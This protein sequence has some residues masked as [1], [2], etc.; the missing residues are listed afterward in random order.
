LMA[1]STV[2]GA[3]SPQGNVTQW[4]QC[5]GRTPLP[6]RLGS[7]ASGTIVSSGDMSAGAAKTAAQ[8]A[9][10]AAAVAQLADSRPSQPGM[11]FGG[12]MA[13]PVASRLVQLDPARPPEVS[14]SNVGSF[15]TI[16]QQSDGLRGPKALMLEARVEELR[17]ELG[18]TTQELAARDRTIADSHSEMT[19]LR[20]TLACRDS[21]IQR[22][23][24]VADS[25]A[26]AE[27]D[28]TE[29]IAQLEAENERLRDQLRGQAREGL[30]PSAE[31]AAAA[32][33]GDGATAGRDRWKQ[34]L[35]DAEAAVSHALEVALGQPDMLRVPRQTRL[36]LLSNTLKQGVLKVNQSMMAQTLQDLKRSASG[37][38]LPPSVSFPTS[39][40]DGTSAS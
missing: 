25:A 27:G 29:R 28:G 32:G 37:S 18:R 11:V 10:A 12:Q 23:K 4:S 31:E 16:S 22:L 6:L 15:E 2:M 5:G 40:A 13:S 26:A 21:E 19:D 7:E 39:S 30:D 36:Q 3:A 1:P 24:A 8:A 34:A 35:A 9:A 33:G 17:R 20:A 38:S 14:L